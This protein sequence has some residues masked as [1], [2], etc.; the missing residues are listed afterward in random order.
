MSFS[1]TDTFEILTRPNPPLMFSAFEIR[2]GNDDNISIAY[3][4]TSYNIIVLKTFFFY[5]SD[6]P[7]VFPKAFHPI[8]CILTK[9]HGPP[10]LSEGYGKM[11]YNFRTTVYLV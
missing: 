2:F 4:S 11:S 9:F 7:S 3:G 1:D 10:S 8:M 6:R 5:L